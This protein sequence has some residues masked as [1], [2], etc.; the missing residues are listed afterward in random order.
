MEQGVNN[1]HR[2]SVGKNPVDNAIFLYSSDIGVKE[3][4][5]ELYLAGFRS[6]TVAAERIKPLDFVAITVPGDASEVVCTFKSFKE[7]NVFLREMA[8]EA[9]SEKDGADRLLLN[10][11]WQNKHEAAFKGF[12]AYS[13]YIY[14]T[15][16]MENA[17]NIVER[18]V[19]V[20]DM[21]DAGLLRPEGMEADR[22]NEKLADIAKRPVDREYLISALRHMD[23]LNGQL[24]HMVRTYEKSLNKA[25]VNVRLKPAQKPK[26][27]ARTVPNC[28]ERDGASMV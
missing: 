9:P 7:A 5:A 25:N 11:E 8:R 20:R 3:P 12:T 17:Q 6:N 2:F 27:Q 4:G 23:G 18:S 24:L 21:Y 10:V 26:P 19:A 14:L 1:K 15:K 22:W 16:E 28:L 13:G